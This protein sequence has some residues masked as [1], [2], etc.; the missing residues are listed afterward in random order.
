MEAL[1]L[2]FSR[3]EDGAAMRRNAADLL[4][5]HSAETIQDVLLVITE[6]VDNVV[7]HTDGGGELHLIRDD[8]TVWIE[9]H[10]HSRE[11][12][13]L[14]RTDPRR[15]GGRGLLLVA[16]VTD[17]WGSK[18]TPTGKLVWARLGQTP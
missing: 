17:R 3:A 10:D 13:L 6:L 2:T 4:A 14:Q 15:P 11:F 12:P 8:D 16:A 1:R 5:G 7:Q 18:P 9:V